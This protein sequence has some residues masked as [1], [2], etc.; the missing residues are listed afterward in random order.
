M[1]KYKLVF[2][3]LKSKIGHDCARK[4]AYEVYNYDS[5]W[6]VMYKRT[7]KFL[8]Y[9]LGYK[10]MKKFSFANWFENNYYTQNLTIKIDEKRK[11]PTH[12]RY[13]YQSSIAKLYNGMFKYFD[14]NRVNYH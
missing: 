2:D 8:K 6:I 12:W 5:K 1:N 4:V 9:D 3:F 7:V 13:N 14:E 11:N 10:Y